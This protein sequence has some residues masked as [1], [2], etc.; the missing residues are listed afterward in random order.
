M[1]R[2]HPAATRLCSPSASRALEDVLAAE[3]VAAGGGV[4]AGGTVATCQ[5]IGALGALAAGPLVLA[6]ALGGFLLTTIGIAIGKLVRAVL[7]PFHT[8][9]GD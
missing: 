3:A 7:D 9:A 8:Q 2:A 5:S 4:A 6:V 1:P